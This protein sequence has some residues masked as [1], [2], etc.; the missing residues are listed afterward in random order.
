MNVSSV[1][2]RAILIAR[3]APLRERTR[4]WKGQ[5]SR[6]R[7]DPGSPAEGLGFEPR[8]PRKGLNSFKTV[9]FVPP[10]PSLRDRA[11]Y[12]L[13]SLAEREGFEPSRGSSP[14]LA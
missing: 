2:A 9:A 7:T 12:G 6:D 11:P 5:E 3:N 14:L 13:G 10:R 1:Q 4:L 8:E